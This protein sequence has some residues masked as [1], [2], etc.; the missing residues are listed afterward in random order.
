MLDR[1][2]GSQMG[3]H[4]DRDRAGLFMQPSLRVGADKGYV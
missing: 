4:V 2:P 3:F 1:D